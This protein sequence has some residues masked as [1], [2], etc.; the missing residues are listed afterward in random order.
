ME[1]KI[2]IISSFLKKYKFHFLLLLFSLIFEKKFLEI[3]NATLVK[4]LFSSIEKSTTFL[5]VFFI[6]SVLLILGLLIFF[7]FSNYHPSKTLTAWIIVTSIIY[8]KFRFF[9]NCF[10]FLKVENRHLPSFAYSDILLLLSIAIIIFYLIR[11]LTNH[12]IKTPK[13]N[14]PNGFYTDI[15][16]TLLKK[17]DD[18]YNRLDFIEELKNKILATN[19]TEKSFAIG[20][21]GKWGD[22]KTTFLNTLE[23]LLKKERKVI[24]LKFNPWM[25]GSADKI[26]EL[27]FSD[28]SGVLGEFDGNLK[29]QI[30]KY[31]K[32]LISSIDES[33]LSIFKDLLGKGNDNLSLVEQN[34]AISTS[35]KNLKARL[36]IY[37][38]DVDRLDKKEVLEVLRLIRNTADFK[39]TFFI[40]A[41]DKTYLIECLKKSDVSKSETYLDKIFQLEYYLP[42]TLDEKA[43]EK[44]FFIEVAKYL[45]T[46]QKLVLQKIA[47]PEPSPFMRANEASPKISMYL[48]NVRDIKRFLNVFLLNFERVKHNIYLPDYI[49]INILRLKYP[50]VY[51][52]LYNNTYKYLTTNKGEQFAIDTNELTLNISDPS[53]SG[54]SNT[55]LFKE[56]GN[57]DKYSLNEITREESCKL[58]GSIF[59]N[60]TSFKRTL[61]NNHLSI[62]HPNSFNR[63][64]DFYMEGRLD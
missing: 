38:D 50:E 19:N 27:F 51:L 4:H 46:D 31:S 42:V 64:F 16:L 55:T 6:L 8:V 36:V 33:G 47:N 39:N 37:I 58:V 29:N 30:V 45:D 26:I 18:I 23:V 61:S 20:V 34:E 3:I 12:F 59:K 17:E 62:I 24:Q 35:I 9:A 22:G 28:L 44:I 13:V 63:Y 40:V 52:E 54:Y 56:L 43:C 41:F 25:A 57:I 2:S 10:D 60:S 21:I 48:K 1:I 5:D 49:A 32:E 7:L 53:S 14:D 11:E 15:P